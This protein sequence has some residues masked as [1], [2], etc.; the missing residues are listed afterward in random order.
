MQ[1]SLAEVEALHLGQ[2]GLGVEGPDAEDAQSQ[3]SV[4]HGLNEQ[5][6]AYDVKLESLTRSF[7]EVRALCLE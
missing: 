2:F 5:R 7:D 3:I 1:D 4:G 6:E